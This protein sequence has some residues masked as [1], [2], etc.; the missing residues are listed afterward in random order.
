MTRNIYEILT[1]GDAA[2]HEA[3]EEAL[4]RFIDAQ[5]SN[6]ESLSATWQKTK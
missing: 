3:F 5:T 4:A 6:L 2:D 1:V